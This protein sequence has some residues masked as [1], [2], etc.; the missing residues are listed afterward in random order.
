MLIKYLTPLSNNL[1]IF[2]S[3]VYLEFHRSYHQIYIYTLCNTLTFISGH[4]ILITRDYMQSI[5]YGDMIVY[6]CKQSLLTNKTFQYVALIGSLYYLAQYL[7]F[8]FYNPYLRYMYHRD[9]RCCGKWQQE[10]AWKTQTFPMYRACPRCTTFQLRSP[11]YKRNLQ[12]SI[13]NNFKV[14]I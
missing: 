11:S 7:S 8:T 9:W 12:I 5:V 3:P 14:K 2:M 13:D 1:N 4:A 10:S 6:T